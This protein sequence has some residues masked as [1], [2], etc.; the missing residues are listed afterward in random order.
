MFQGEGMSSDPFENCDVN[1]SRFVS[2]VLMAAF[3]VSTVLY[4]VGG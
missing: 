2:L 4:H 3:S 1:K